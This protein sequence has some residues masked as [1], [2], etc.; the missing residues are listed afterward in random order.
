MKKKYIQKEKEREREREREGE[1]EKQ[2]KPTSQK[3]TI[4]CRDTFVIFVEQLEMGVC[5]AR[6]GRIRQDYYA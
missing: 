2:G 3:G 5:F 1:R 4:G 6:S